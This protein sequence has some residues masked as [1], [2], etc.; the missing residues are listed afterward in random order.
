MRGLKGKTAVVTGGAQG[1]GEAI[2]QRLSEE[3]MTV[4]LLDRS[5][6]GNDTA[7]RIESRSGHAVRFEQV[8]IRDEAAIQAAFQRIGAEG[9]G[10]VDVLVNNAAVFVFKGVEA[11]A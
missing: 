5:E 2:V 11:T 7:A 4:W 8:D 10:A 6:E 3:G 9:A 1:L